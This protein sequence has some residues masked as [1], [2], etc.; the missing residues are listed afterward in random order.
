MQYEETIAY[1]NLLQKLSNI[2]TH[3]GSNIMKAFDL[4]KFTSS[5]TEDGD[6]D[7]MLLDS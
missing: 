3:N 2:I 4:S 5:T 6:D 7:V 1:F